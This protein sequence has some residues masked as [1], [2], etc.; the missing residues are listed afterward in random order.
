MLAAQENTRKDA[1]E[2]FAKIKIIATFVALRDIRCAEAQIQIRFEGV[3][4]A[5][6]SFVFY[7][8]TARLSQAEREFETKVFSFT[9]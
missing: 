1:V 9:N 8:K 2:H 4:F 6:D 3:V 5:C 7:T